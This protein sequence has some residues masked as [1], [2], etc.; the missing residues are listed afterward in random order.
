MVSSNTRSKENSFEGKEI[1]KIANK[2]DLSMNQRGREKVRKIGGFVT[3]LAIN[4]VTRLEKDAS[5]TS[6]RQRHN[7]MFKNGDNED[8][9]DL[10][11]SNL[12]K[13]HIVLLVPKRER[14]PKNN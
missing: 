8:D 5:T 1:Q 13:E 11:K 10:G 4:I 2:L 7:N 14:S 6:P 9:I 12:E 3:Q